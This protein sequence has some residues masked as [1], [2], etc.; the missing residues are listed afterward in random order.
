MTGITAT[1][2]VSTFLTRT[3]SRPREQ[4]P[5]PRGAHAPRSPHRAREHRNLWGAPPG[6]SCLPLV[7]FRP[8]YAPHRTRSGTTMAGVG[9]A[10]ETAGVVRRLNPQRK[11]GRDPIL[12][13]WIPVPRRQCISHSSRSFV[14]PVL[15]AF[16]RKTFRVARLHLISTGAPLVPAS[17]RYIGRGPGNQP[18]QKTPRGNS[19]RHQPRDYKLS[20]TL[21][22][23]LSSQPRLI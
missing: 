8:T 23:P 14:P 3:G 21:V 19:P 12:S 1:P 5:R 22:P 13:R 18:R 2:F 20:V 4:P 11:T 6:T 7:C 10:L 17:P 16:P 9:G 15:V